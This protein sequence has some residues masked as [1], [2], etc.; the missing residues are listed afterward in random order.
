MAWAASASPPSFARS[1]RGQP[2]RVPP[3]CALDGSTIEPTQ[4]GFL[5]ALSVAIGGELAS[6]EG[7]ADRLGSLGA[8]VVVVLDEYDALRAID[9]WLCRVVV[10]ALS[11]R[12]RLV[13]A[14]REAPIPDWPARL[15]ELLQVIAVGNLPP[16][17]ATALLA[18]EGVAAPEAARIERLARGH[19]LS[20]RLAAAALRSD[21]ALVSG[22]PDLVAIMSPITRLYLDALDP[23]T[24][25]VV[26]AACVVRRPTRS[27]LTTM[28][29]DGPPDAFERLSGLPFVEPTVDG[30]A[31]HATVREV[32]AASLR[33]D[34][35]E[36]S[37]AHRIAAWRALRREVADASPTNLWRYTA[38]LLYLVE[39]E[40]IHDAFFPTTDRRYVVDEARPEDWPV[41]R[42]LSTRHFPGEPQDDLEAWW[43]HA[44]W[45]FRVARSRTG[46]A[47]GFAV[48]AELDRLPR[49]LVDVDPIARHWRDHRRRY[50]VP[51]GR[52]ISTQRFERADP[53]DQDDASIH[54]SLILDL[55]H[56]WIGPATGPRASL[57][58]GA[59]AHRDIERDPPGRRD[60]GP[61]R[62]PDA[63][64]RLPA[65]SVRHRVRGGIGRRLAR[66]ADRHGS[67]H[68]RRATPRRRP[69]RER[70]R[71][72]AHPAHDARV[73]RPPL[74]GRAPRH[75]R[76]PADAP[77]RRVG[78]RR[79]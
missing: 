55:Y 60:A 52:T 36:R 22:D 42:Q 12:T 13:M 34:D 7:L 72:S 44:P 69:A 30:L 5:A 56:A 18:A 1:S 70:A 29:P 76:R 8:L 26:D 27:L 66:P 19:P 47:A 49:V 53:A 21:P 57:R 63:G 62:L 51:A 74:P 11:D 31:I 71:G 35:P 75:H 41:I 79:G 33:A 68:R 65:L 61:G 24:R 67:A 45:A 6:V 58:I 43:R 77:A 17:R 32:V 50:P 78:L 28:L 73:R 54:A 10:P 39:N 64:R 59:D 46:D 2:P 14:G 3:S 4:R 48:A 16:A 9:P 15:G 20:L 25:S 38:D 23:V 40:T 37:R